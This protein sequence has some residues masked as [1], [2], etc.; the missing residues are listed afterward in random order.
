MKRTK[1]YIDAPTENEVTYKDLIEAAVTQCTTA[2]T[3]LADLKTLLKL[4]A[5]IRQKQLSRLRF[6]ASQEFANAKSK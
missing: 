2:K 6:A 3:I 1:K 5:V 4:R